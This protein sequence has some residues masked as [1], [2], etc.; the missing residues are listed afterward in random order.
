MNIQIEVPGRYWWKAEDCIKPAH[1]ELCI[2]H[3]MYGNQSVSIAMYIDRPYRQGDRIV[4]GFF[5][6]V[7]DAWYEDALGASDITES[8]IP[9]GTIDMWAPLGLPEA[10][11]KELKRKTREILLGD[12]E[13]EYMWED[14]EYWNKH[15]G[16]TCE[17]HLS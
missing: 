17:K 5:I 13:G 7:G 9:W 14:K 6:S 3:H 10:L 15:E 1:E 11:D 2:V 8:Y 4:N 12:P 16:I